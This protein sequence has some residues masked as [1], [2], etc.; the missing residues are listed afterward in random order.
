MPAFVNASLSALLFGHH[1]L[2]VLA[3]ADP[4]QLQLLVGGRRILE[5]VRIVLLDVLRA[6]A[7]HDNAVELVGIGEADRHRLA[8]AHRQAADGAVVGVLQRPELLLDE[9]NH[10]VQQ[11]LAEQ[12]AADL[13]RRARSAR[14]PPA[15]PARG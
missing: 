14:S 2:V 9:R 8:A 10:V 4:Q 1:Q 7:H 11:I 15:A 13:R 12:A 5:E 6:G 3:D